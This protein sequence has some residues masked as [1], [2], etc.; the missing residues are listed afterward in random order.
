MKQMSRERMVARY[1]EGYGRGEGVNYRPWITAQDGPSLGVITQFK[2]RKTGRIHVALSN[3]EKHTI[4]AVQWL[5]HVTDIREQW[6]LWPLEETEAIAAGLGVKHP[7]DRSGTNI[8]MTTDVLLTT[9]NVPVSL[10]PITV[11]PETELS[12]SRVLEKFEIERVYWERRGC[13]LGIVTGRQ[14]PQ[15]LTSN[16]EWVDGCHEIT[17][18]TLSVTEIARLANHLFE[19]LQAEPDNP[20]RDLCASVDDR[21][22]YGPGTSLTV[23]RHALSRKLW[24]VP[25]DRKIET[26]NPLPTPTRTAP[27]SDQAGASG[28]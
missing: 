8:V 9:T 1:N 23:V 4:R 2:G 22:G 14:L 15:A 3:L 12:N 19:L 11:K 28:Q 10:E 24:T 20:L 16:L 13:R 21:L 25:F 5:N 27:M 7:A 6:P 26:R 18:E 17:A